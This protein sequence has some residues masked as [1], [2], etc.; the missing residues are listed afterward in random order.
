MLPI[1]LG[2]FIVAPE[3]HPRTQNGA[4]RSTTIT[5]LMPVTIRLQKHHCSEN[6]FMQPL[7]LL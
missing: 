5:K 2:A 7:A 6:S 4:T 3:R 1:E